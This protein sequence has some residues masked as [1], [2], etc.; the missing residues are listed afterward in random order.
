M[1]PSLL[2]PFLILMIFA[3]G[4]NVPLGYMREA[5]PKYSLS[6]F[7]YIHLSIPFIVALRTSAGF[8]WEVVPFSLGCAVAGQ[9]LGGF[10]RRASRRS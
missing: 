2:L 4:I 9:L 10:L 3:L 7:I 6:W 5:S 8:G 1:H